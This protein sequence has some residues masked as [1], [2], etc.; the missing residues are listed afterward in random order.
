MSFSGAGVSNS[1]DSDSGVSSDSVVSPHAEQPCVVA[2]S[3]SSIQGNKDVGG[4][5]ENVEGEQSRG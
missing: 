4:V 2:D 5:G 3:C 1:V